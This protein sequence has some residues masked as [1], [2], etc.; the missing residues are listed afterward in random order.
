M[1]RIREREIAAQS[2]STELGAGSR[3]AAAWRQRQNMKNNET[4]SMV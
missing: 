3:E 1:R 2:E 4:N